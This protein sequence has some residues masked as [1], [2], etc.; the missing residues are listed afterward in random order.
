[1]SPEQ[2]RRNAPPSQVGGPEIAWDA[3]PLEAKER[4]ECVCLAFEDAWKSGS[5]PSLESH[6]EQAPDSI[7]PVLLRELLLL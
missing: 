1:M 4:I 2:D 7:R 5:Q 3:L 6:L